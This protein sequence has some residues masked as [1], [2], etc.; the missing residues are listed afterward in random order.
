M[1]EYKYSLM[2]TFQSDE[3]GP[4][5]TSLTWEALTRGDYVGETYAEYLLKVEKELEGDV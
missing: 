2:D 4:I 5:Y 1:P 3:N